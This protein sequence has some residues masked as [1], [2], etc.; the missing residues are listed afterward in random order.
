MMSLS[1]F[2]PPP[3]PTT[4]RMWKYLGVVAQDNAGWAEAHYAIKALNADLDIDREA[5]LR[6]S[7]LQ[8]FDCVVSGA[9]PNTIDPDAC[10]ALSDGTRNP[11]LVRFYVTRWGGEATYHSTQ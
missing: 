4:H 7:V 6:Q 3:A 11:V 10:Y 1:R 2:P 8:L 9:A 5:E